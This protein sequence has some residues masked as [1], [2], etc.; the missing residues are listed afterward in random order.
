[1]SQI[2]AVLHLGF[3]RKNPVADILIKI[4]DSQPTIGRWSMSYKKTKQTKK[5]KKP[6]AI[7]ALVS[8]ILFGACDQLNNDVAPIAE[9]GLTMPSEVYTT[10]NTPVVFDLRKSA[11]MQQSSA[12]H[13]KVLPKK[14]E[15]KNHQNGLLS[16]TPD[17]TFNSGSDFFVMEGLDA[18]GAVTGFD[19]VQIVVVAD[20][21]SIPCLNGALADYVEMMENTELIIDVLNNDGICEMH[22]SAI[23][24]QMLIDPLNGIAT[25]ENDSLVKYVPN[26]DFTGSDEFFYSLELTDASGDIYQ[27]VASVIVNVFGEV[28]FTCRNTLLDDY[29]ELEQ[30]IEGNF[31]LDVAQNDSLCQNA[32]L[33]IVTS[34]VH[35]HAEVFEDQ[36]GKQFISYHVENRPNTQLTDTLGYSVSDVVGQT[37]T[38][39]V[40]IRISGKDCISTFV[41]DEYVVNLDTLSGDRTVLIDVFQNDFI[42]NI[43]SIS[44]AISEEND[45]QGEAI[46]AGKLIQYTVPA[47]FES[48]SE[49][50][51]LYT[52]CED[53]QCLHRGVTIFVD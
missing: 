28:E 38:A 19:S 26:T 50:M 23:K 13:T 20:T 1:L 4:P 22:L 14:G 52:V 53:G 15:L 21:S 2:L 51:V 36:N 47:S 45:S 7:T 5:M 43:D 12:Y 42:C 32:L 16:Y 9:E 49:D 10:A 37:R 6:I 41:E 40:T 46:V 8:A 24:L 34:P 25:V 11:T 18:Q 29:F 39:T 27:S 33:Y 31:W 17:S 30:G 44:L 35:G 3:S 48:G